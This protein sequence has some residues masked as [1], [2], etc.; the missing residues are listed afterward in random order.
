MAAMNLGPALPTRG[1][2]GGGYAAE[3]RQLAQAAP[4]IKA[5]YEQIARTAHSAPVVDVFISLRFAEAKTEAETLKTALEASGMR[6]FLCAV[7]AGDDLHGKIAAAMVAAKL[8]VIMGTA[9]Y[10]MKTN[11]PCGTYEEL[12]YT[13]GSRKPFFLVKMCD[14]FETPLAQF[15]LTSGVMYHPWRP[16]TPMPRDLVGKID[17]KLKSLNL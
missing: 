6:V 12:Q 8:V 10:G 15:N 4:A 14:R 3:L 17:E 9:T 5:N 7:N 1:L 2:S 16:N 11:S 13:L